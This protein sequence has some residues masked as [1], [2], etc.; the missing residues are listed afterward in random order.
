MK[1]FSLFLATLLLFCNPIGLLAANGLQTHL[2]EAYASYMEGANADEVSE[3]QTA[4]NRALR[5]YAQL[6][7]QPGNGKLFYNMANAYYELGEYGWAIYYYRLAQQLLPRNALIKQQLT[8]ALVKQG[9]PPPLEQPIA[10]NVLYW[11][12]KMSQPERIQLFLGLL[13]ATF[14]SASW[15]VWVRRE[16]IKILCGVLTACTTLI[17]GSILYTQYFAP[18]QAVTVEAYGL[19]HAPTGDSAIVSAE[20]LIPGTTLQIHDIVDDGSWLRVS[21]PQGQTGYL[22]SEAAR[23]IL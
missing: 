16:P 1:P 14:L 23:L 15:L 22:P 10:Q 8:H 20:P 5:L 17:L 11:Q 3:R 18:L 21:I 6:E 9:F 13:A 19:Y 2:D 7:D 4:Y 12:Y